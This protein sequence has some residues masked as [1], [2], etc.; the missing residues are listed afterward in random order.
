MKAHPSAALLHVR[1]KRSA[2]CG[3][4]G[5]GVQKHHYLIRSKK[6][7]IEIV[8]IGR[9][10]K[11]EMIFGRDFLKPSLGFTDKGELCLMLCGDKERAH[12]ERWLAVMDARRS[13]GS[14]RPGSPRA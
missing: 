3:F 8:A 5:A 2:L 9:G 12:P 6:V 7:C 10:V 4:F 13:T 1:L 11:A 14:D